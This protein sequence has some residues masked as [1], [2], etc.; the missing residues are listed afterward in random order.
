LEKRREPEVFAG[1]ERG[2]STIGV[3][4]GASKDRKMSIFRGASREIVGSL[5]L[6]GATI[7]AVTLHY[8]GAELSTAV[9]IFLAGLIVKILLTA[10]K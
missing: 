7:L 3:G 2:T 1:G 9:T 8:R 4:G 5:I 6:A 10:I